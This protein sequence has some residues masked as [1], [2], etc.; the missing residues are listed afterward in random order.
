MIQISDWVTTK[1]GRVGNVRNFFRKPS[2][3]QGHGMEKWAEVQFGP[4]G[5]FSNFKVRNLRLA[6]EDERR[7]FEGVGV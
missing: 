4:S 1:D 7:P 6:T 5:P 3:R 2:I